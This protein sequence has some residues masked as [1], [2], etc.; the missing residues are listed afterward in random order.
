MT[1]GRGSKGIDGKEGEG[2]ESERKEVKVSG[3]V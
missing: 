3:R 1:T 2:K